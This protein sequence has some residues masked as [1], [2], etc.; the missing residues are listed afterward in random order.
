M[1]AGHA[2]CLP[3]YL[4]GAAT[5][6]LM[7]RDSWAR[8]EAPARGVGCLKGLSDS[9]EGPSLELTIVDTEGRTWPGGSW[10]GVRAESRGKASKEQGV[11]DRSGPERKQR[12]GIC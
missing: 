3:S 1:A 8:R 7:E 12:Q 11:R 9:K 2:S 5:N 10:V 4:K 6:P